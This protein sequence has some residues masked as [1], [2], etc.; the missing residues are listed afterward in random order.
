MIKKKPNTVEPGWGMGQSVGTKVRK[1]LN[2]IPKTHTR[3]QRMVDI[4]T[5]TLG[6]WRHVELWA[7][8]PAILA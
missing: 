3:S 1:D 7:L 6:G 8:P 2:L 5:S 4:V